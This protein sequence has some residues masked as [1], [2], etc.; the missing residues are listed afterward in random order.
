MTSRSYARF[1]APAVLCILC[2]L[3]LPG[4]KAVGQSSTQ[5]APASTQITAGDCA[6]VLANVKAG[7]SVNVNI[8]CD[9]PTETEILRLL[10]SAPT[11]ESCFAQY[12]A[13][14]KRSWD[15]MNNMFEVYPEGGSYFAPFDF[16]FMLAP[17]GGSSGYE[18]LFAAGAELLPWEQVSKKE[19]WTR[20]D[21]D[22]IVHLRAAH[23]GVA[24]DTHVIDELYGLDSDP[25]FNPKST[26][27]FPLRVK[28]SY[29]DGNEVETDKVTVRVGKD[30]LFAGTHLY[31][32]IDPYPSFDSPPRTMWMVCAA[33]ARMRTSTF[34]SL[35]RFLMEQVTLHDRFPSSECR[36]SQN[37]RDIE[38]ASEE[39]DDGD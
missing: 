33:N 12:P 14:W 29:E 2:P 22:R 25:P 19:G 11:K 17:M 7:G 38:F 35:C 37:M 23:P 9:V 31:P 16:R 34:K 8:K 21:Y 26:D 18:T 28:V 27:S 20:A 3:C 10:L 36:E 39:D 32:Y 5:T 24:V 1:L 15:G 6:A 30:R 13:R 4:G